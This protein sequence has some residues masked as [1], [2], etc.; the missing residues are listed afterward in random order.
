MFYIPQIR[1][2]DCGIA[3]LKMLLVKFHDDI[4]YQYL[5]VD[6]RKSG[7]SYQDLIDIA[8]KNS[9]SLEGIK[10]VEK[11][12]IAKA[13][14][15]PMIVTLENKD[16]SKHAVVVEKVR[17]K[18]VYILDPILGNYSLSISKFIKLWDSTALIMTDFEKTP[19]TMKD[20]AS[21]IQ[22]NNFILAYLL[23]IF[24]GACFI[25][26]LYFLAPND[27]VALSIV[28]FASGAI[29]QIILR[30]YLIKLMHKF[31]ESISYKRYITVNRYD[32]FSRCEEYKKVFFSTNM[33]F[34]YYLIA[35]AFVVI[36][37]ILNRFTNLILIAVC[38][39]IALFETTIFTPKL[40]RDERDIS[41][42]EE[43]IKNIKDENKF[44]DNIKEIRTSS[45][46]I[47]KWVSFKN[48]CYLFVI[49]LSCTLITF[50]NEF[51]LINIVFNVSICM[52]LKDNLINLLS[53][54]E[55][56][57]EK[58]YY[59]IRLNNLLCPSDNS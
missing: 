20:E 44:N 29:L 32:F 2:D 22:N 55:K 24:S 25:S 19:C 23:Q 53:Y 40:K 10:V 1:K 56:N 52:L 6:E 51:N 13:N 12:D 38:V 58:R 34:L 37:A 48:I 15:L 46:R 18:R 50:L 28:F 57:I 26:G 27:N 5:K 9:L 33:N 30:Y 59:S 21:L 49:I 36:I 11:S 8:E 47:A 41:I 42:S 43:K 17:F 14:K 39:V 7:Y 3:C 16:G 54:N 45:Y 31:D 4:N 35:C